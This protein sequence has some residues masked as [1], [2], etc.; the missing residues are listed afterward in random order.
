MSQGEMSR[1]CGVDP[2]RVGRA[3]EKEGLV[4]RK[5]DPE[6]G[7]VVR[8]YLTEEGRRVLVER[9]EVEEPRSGASWG[10]TSQATRAS[11]TSLGTVPLVRRE[12]N[13]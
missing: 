5:C 9:P 3:L 1:L 13:R 11:S 12:R 10:R 2:A 4:R 6:D 7:R 8:L